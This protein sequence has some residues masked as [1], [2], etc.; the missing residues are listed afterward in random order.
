MNKNKYEYSRGKRIKEIRIKRGLSQKELADLCDLQ[1]QRIS[2]YERDVR[3]PK[4]ETVTKIANALNVTAIDILSPN[5]DEDSDGYISFVLSDEFDEA[6]H[7]QF[8]FDLKKNNLLFVWF[9]LKEMGYTISF[10]KDYPNQ[11]KFFIEEE[12]VTTENLENNNYVHAF[13]SKEEVLKIQEE[14]KS[15]FKFRLHE[16]IKKAE[17]EQR[18][19]ETK[20]TK[21]E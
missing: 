13:V 17:L 2:E 8:M 16:F 4:M 12:N 7:E 9:L 11:E 10:E 20:L 3:N 15:F 21:K 18:Q 19:M 5:G 1:C 14:S 6:V